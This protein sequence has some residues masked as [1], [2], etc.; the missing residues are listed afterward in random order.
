[1]TM[2]A[3]SDGFHRLGRFDRPGGTGEPQFHRLIHGMAADPAKDHPGDQRVSGPRHLVD[4]DRRRQEEIVVER[5]RYEGAFLPARDHHAA[6]PVAH[7]AISRLADIQRRADRHMGQ[8]ACLVAV[9]EQRVDAA[10]D[11]LKP[12]AL[13]TDTQST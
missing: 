11:A 1:M 9:G 8:V 5:R 7:Q 6:D 12:A 13:A 3:L 10:Q 2:S 4:I